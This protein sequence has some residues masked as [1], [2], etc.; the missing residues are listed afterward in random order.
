MMDVRRVA[1]HE[2][3]HAVACL[4]TGVR[5]TAVTA[6]P[7]AGYLGCVELDPG[8]EHRGDPDYAWVM[9][10][11]IVADRIMRN[12]AVFTPNTIKNWHSYGFLEPDVMALIT[13]IPDRDTLLGLVRLTEYRTRGCWPAVTDIAGALID[14]GTLTYAEAAGLAG[15]AGDRCRFLSEQPAGAV[16]S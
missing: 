3:G 9:A 13:E 4:A 14:R 7:A 6:V 10:G 11:G 2:A 16:M 15:C 12:R 1:Y 5:F 8:Q